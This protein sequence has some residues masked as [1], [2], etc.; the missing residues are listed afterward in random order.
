VAEFAGT[1]T[2]AAAETVEAALTPSPTFIPPPVSEATTEPATAL[3]PSATET[4]SLVIPPGGVESGPLFPGGV[5]DDL[6]VGAD[7]VTVVLPIAAIAGIAAATAAAIGNS[8][9]WPG[10][11][12]A[13]TNA[14]L[15]P[16]AMSD[17]A[18]RLESAGTAVTRAGS[19]LADAIAHPVRDG[20]D[21]AVS[22][23]LFSEDS[24]GLRDARLLAQIGIVLGTIYVAFLTVWFWATRVRWNLR[25]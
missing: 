7:P 4:G 16:T 9:S 3:V 14:R 17:A 5:I 2:A 8:G 22:R 24:E 11:S 10:T 20:F 21:R 18:A 13:V 15:L 12:V 1:S 19:G 6:L 25:A 23:P